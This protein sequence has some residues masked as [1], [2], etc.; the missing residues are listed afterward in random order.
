MS[1]AESS[2]YLGSVIGGLF[3]HN[4][5]G[6]VDLVV[7]DRTRHSFFGEEFA[8][9]TRPIVAIECMK[10]LYSLDNDYANGLFM[11]YLGLMGASSR[12][13]GLAL[14]VD[15]GLVERNIRFIQQQH[16]PDYVDFLSTYRQLATGEFADNSS[17][18]HLS[19]TM[20]FRLE[21]HRPGDLLPHQGY[22]G[23]SAHDIAVVR[24]ELAIS[25]C[26]N[27]NSPTVATAKLLLLGFSPN[28]I[29]QVSQLLNRDGI[30]DVVR[31]L[32]GQAKS[33]FEAITRGDLTNSE[34]MNLL[35]GIG[36][37]KKRIGTVFGI[38]DRRVSMMLRLMRERGQL[39]EYETASHLPET[40][41][42]AYLLGLLVKAGSVTSDNKSIV[43]QNL[44][45]ETQE[46]FIAIGRGLFGR[47]PSRTAPGRVSFNKRIVAELFGDLRIGHWPETIT[48]THKWI[49]EDPALLRA[50]V[51][52][53]VDVA[54]S[55]TSRTATFQFPHYNDARFLKEM[56]E[57]LGIT[58][59][60]IYKNRRHDRE[61]F[62]LTISATVNLQRF[63]NMFR[64]V[65]PVKEARLAY[66][67]LKNPNRPWEKVISFDEVLQEWVKLMR[68]A[69]GKKPSNSQVISSYRQGLTRWGRSFYMF[70]FGQ[71]PDGRHTWSQAA[72]YLTEEAKKRGLI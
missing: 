10:N 33:A 6:L 69:D 47:E 15:V 2:S 34:K 30:N 49:L 23:V 12:S 46:R 17:R 4:R 3:R 39:V 21:T 32:D 7:V 1:T 62:R 19:K 67:R 13:I 42:T 18:D 53:I 27:T 65:I 64:S 11:W 9:L 56:L 55:T 25:T 68:A 54:C 43:S 50:F 14:G 31:R 36:I 40:A 35:I 71:T 59:V 29:L 45:K 57:Q 70:R 28:E 8:S 52:G 41:D 66:W 63:A 24:N 5:A 61:D 51:S 44:A 48:S 22:E 37:P 16:D 26:L 60:K 58:R 38:S 72:A 20:R